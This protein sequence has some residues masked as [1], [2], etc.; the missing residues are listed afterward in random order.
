MNVL[1]YAIAMPIAFS[2]LCFLSKRASPWIALAISAAETIM[3]VQIFFCY[4]NASPILYFH[5]SVL[6]SGIF[7]A[8]SA[9]SLLIALYSFK[10]MENSERLGEYY[11]YILITI[12][13]AAGAL[14]ANDYLTLLSF[15][16]ILGATLYMLIGIS[17]PNAASAAKK[18][19][20][21]VGGSDALMIFGIGTIWLMTRSLQIGM[22]PISM[23]GILPAVAFLSLLA[24]ALA[25]A[26]AMPFHSWIPDCAEAAPI[27]VTA[28]LPASLD[29]LLGIYL[30]FRLCTDIFQVTPNSP[31]SILLLAIGSFTIIA[32]VMA[33]L[34]QHNMRKLLSFHAVSQV[35]YMVL[36]IGTGL[37]VG[38]AG[39]LFHM[40]N[41]TIY[42]TCLFLTG[43]SV[44]KETGTSELDKLGGIGK[45][46]PITFACAAVAALSISGVPPFN[47]FFSKWMVYQGI[48]ELSG[49]SKLWVVWLCAAMFGSALTLASFV[50]LIHAVYLGQGS[51]KKPEA[52]EVSWQM[53]L[54]PAILALLC[55][56]FG[57]FA[58]S[59][60]LAY[61]IL[62][63]VGGI[64]YTGYWDPSL[65]TALIL[66]GL[67]IGL[68]VYWLGKKRTALAGP[69]YIGGEVI[70]EAG[71]KVL[72]TGFYNTIRDYGP[73][74]GIFNFAERKLFDVYELGSKL[75]S[76]LY[77]VLGFLHNGLLHTYLAWMFLGFAVIMLFMIF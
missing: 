72:G 21:I 32:G 4:G 66:A 77:D 52:R 34:V 43:G 17:G 63:S 68:L 62:P 29:K 19:F 58:S 56:V 2:L 10:F 51:G 1:L 64:I 24:G 9:F 3:A 59:I 69:A 61:F 65:A 41:H 7:L 18:T 73:L 38:M 33:A 11:G 75:V 74:D 42:K 55:I 36:G 40:L 39:A 44:E 13:A 57:V 46:M 76:L 12:G 50:K 8:A 22:F 26:G 20:I 27:P 28:Y 25:K 6:N 71:V 45:A 35:G 49:T 30:L 70:E 15:W 47:G 67:L 54:P 16:G 14:F 31:V 23:Y 37:P 48:I 60:P 53:W 5:A